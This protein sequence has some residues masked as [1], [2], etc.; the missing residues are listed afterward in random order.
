M[1]HEKYTAIAKMDLVQRATYIWNELGSLLTIG[2]ILFV[3]TQIWTVLYGTKEVI[4]GFTLTQ[5]IWYL[6]FTETLMFAQAP[7]MIRDIGEQVRRGDIAMSLLKPYSFVGKLLSETASY[8]AFKFTT[9]GII[10]FALVTNFVGPLLFD[11]KILP[12]IGILVI[13]SALVNFFIVVSFGLLALYLEDV[14][15][16]WWIYS[17]LT[18]ILGGML[19]P[20]EVY[21]EWF[22]K[23]LYHLP[24]SYIMYYPAKLFVHFD[25]TLFY[26]ALIGLIVYSFVFGIIVSIIFTLGKRRISLHGG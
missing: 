11:L 12:F 26:Q 2:V 6:A 25:W 21:P 1:K 24:T 13:L 20:L 16:F 18:F 7:W 23:W 4:E 8:F 17:K 5:M 14:G 10:A 3:F 22:A 19:V 9:T 15:A